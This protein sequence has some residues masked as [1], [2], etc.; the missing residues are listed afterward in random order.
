MRRR[1]YLAGLCMPLLAGCLGDDNETPVETSFS[2]TGDHVEDGI[3]IEEG[4]TVLESTHEGRRGFKVMLVSE[5]GSSHAFAMHVGEYHGESP[6]LLEAGTYS[7]EV[8]ADGPWEVDI[9]QPREDY[10]EAVPDSLSDTRPRV[11]GPYKF[12]GEYDA[13]GVHE[14]SGDFNVWIYP[15]DISSRTLLFTD[16][17][18]VD[19][20]TTFEHEGVGWVA[21]EAAGEWEVEFL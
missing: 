6:S 7:L 18:S 19:T 17:G 9:T 2:G 10:G 5:A 20:E 15:Q 3:D 4:L 8:D 1:A 21:V 12:E 14:G 11:F 13:T 16:L